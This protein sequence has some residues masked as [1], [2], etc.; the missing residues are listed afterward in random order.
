MKLNILI[1]YLFK[2]KWKTKLP[3]KNRFVL[4]DGDHNPFL[5]YIDK[6]LIIILN[7]PS[8]NKRTIGCFPI[9]KTND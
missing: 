2:A 4:I 8:G 9:N 5:K 3:E 1:K 6:V 7:Q